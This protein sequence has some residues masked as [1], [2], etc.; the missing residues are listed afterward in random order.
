MKKTYGSYS[1]QFLYVRFLVVEVPMYD[2]PGSVWGGDLLMGEAPRV[3][4]IVAQPPR[5]HRKS[6]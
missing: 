2:S 6:I 1:V 4:C 5:F 3:L